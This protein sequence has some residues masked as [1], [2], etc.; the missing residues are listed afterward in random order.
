MN[1][2]IAIFDSG[3]G[4]FTVVKDIIRLLPHESVVYVGDTARAPYGTKAAT[5]IIQFADEICAYLMK[6]DPKLIVIACNTATAIALQYLQKKYAIPIIGVIEA[7]VRSALKAS[8]GGPIG[9]IGTNATINSQAYEQEIRKR[10]PFV[11]VISYAC[12]SFV[13]LVEQG[14]YEAEEACEKV[15]QELYQLAQHRIDCLILGCTHY[16][17]LKGSIQRVLG[18][19]VKLIHSGYETAKQ[20]KALLVERREDGYMFSPK[21][22]DESHVFVCSGALDLFREIGKKWLADDLYGRSCEWKTMQ[23]I[24]IS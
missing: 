8:K 11:E 17:F 20:V 2:P 10:N 23:K 1:R 9:V 21:I 7:G 12:P 16:P 13:P 14:K 3:V 18:H 24:T 5:E 4:G 22:T 19:E 15:K 6:F